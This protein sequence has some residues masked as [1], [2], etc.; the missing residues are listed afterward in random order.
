MKKVSI[1]DIFYWLFGLVWVLGWTKELAFLYAVMNKHKIEY[2][3]EEIKFWMPIVLFF[4][5]PY[6]Y[7]YG[8][9]L[10]KK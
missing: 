2:P 5:W 6:T 8:K 9:A 3:S 10:Q 7:F 4:T 1:M